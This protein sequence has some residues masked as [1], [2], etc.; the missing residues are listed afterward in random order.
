MSNTK[1]ALNILTLPHLL[2]RQYFDKEE[3]MAQACCNFCLVFIKVETGYNPQ[4]HKRYCSKSC[5]VADKIFDEWQS[6]EEYNRK[7]HYKELT[8]GEG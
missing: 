5:M 1:V 7:R 4:I 8:K 3:E 6:E 2:I